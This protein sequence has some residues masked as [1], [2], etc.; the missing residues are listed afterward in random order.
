MSLLSPFAMGN[1][2]A[3]HQPA[4]AVETSLPSQ[5]KLLRTRMFALA[6]IFL[7][8]LSR[9]IT[10]YPTVSAVETRPS[11]D[12][13]ESL[14]QQLGDESYATRRRA[15]ESLQR[16]GLEAFD[17]LQSAQFHPDNEI[18]LTAR[19]LI[20]SLNVS[21][22]KEGD[23]QEVRETLQE[24]GGLEERDRER[25]IVKLASFTNRSG[26]AALVRITNYERSN[27]L[28]LLAAM[29][30]MQQ[31]LLAEPETNASHGETILQ[32]LVSNERPANI[33]LYQYANDLVQNKY[34]AA[35]W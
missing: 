31:E 27:R 22:S 32:T 5:N 12:Q 7:F 14:I 19:F 23:S 29:E 25:R 1:A 11:R 6:C 26:L 8:L 21:W 20:S 15:K 34:S 10:Q 35:A 28:R 24:Y 16:I 2:K 33:W 4:M 17:Q 9:D 30:I 18:A 13:V 3:L